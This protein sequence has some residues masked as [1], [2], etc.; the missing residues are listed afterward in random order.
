MRNG[1]LLTVYHSMPSK[2]RD[3]IKVV[4]LAS[5][6][7]TVNQIHEGKSILGALSQAQIDCIA[8]KGMEL[9]KLY[10]REHMRQMAD[11]DVLVRAYQYDAV[12]ATMEKLGYQ[13]DGESSWK[14]DNFHRNDITVE[15]HKRLTDDSEFIQQWENELWDRTTPTSTEGVYE[16][17]KEDFYIFHFVHL[18]KD[19]M[20]GSLG[21]RRIVDTWLLEKQDSLDMQYIQEKLRQFGMWTFHEKMT[22]LALAA[23]GEAKIDEDAEILLCHAFKHGIYGSG[24]S[25]KTGRIVAMSSGS[26]KSGKLRSLVA[27]VFLP[28]SRMKAQFPALEKWPLLLP[29][30]WVK[31]I[32]RFLSGDV[33]VYLKQL[34]Y[35]NV[36]ESDYAEMQAFFRAGGVR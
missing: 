33:R 3:A 8:L 35:K 9:R 15:I 20:N 36:D 7:Q 23:M 11:I 30:Y 6:A 24:K 22:Q 32:C 29:F 27:A 17:S 4:Y 25:Y 1:V 19:F 16:M 10:P 26:L 12:S 13:S 2:L 34:N 5:V 31:R 28:Y 18:H 21:L 14:H